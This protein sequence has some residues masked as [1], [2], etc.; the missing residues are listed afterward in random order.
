MVGY[1][2]MCIVGVMAII[3][4]FHELMQCHAVRVMHKS[5]ASYP[6]LPIGSPVLAG[7]P[8]GPRSFCQCLGG[9]RGGVDTKHCARWLLRP[10][11]DKGD[12]I[13]WMD[14]RPHCLAFLRP[15]LH[16]LPSILGFQILTTDRCNGFSPPTLLPPHQ[17]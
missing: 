15:S 17:G 2:A 6:S 1:R 12:G 11:E 4:M 13:H 16:L 10:R 3:A 5:F 8:A 14:P 9:L 7:G